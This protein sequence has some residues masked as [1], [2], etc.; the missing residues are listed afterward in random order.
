MDISNSSKELYLWIEV[1]SRIDSLPFDNFN[2]FIKL[3]D[4]FNADHEKIK[5]TTIKI[6][7]FLFFR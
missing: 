7:L 2:E 4:I 6:Q 3:L 5:D 1:L